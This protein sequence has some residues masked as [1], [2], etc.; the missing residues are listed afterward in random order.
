MCLH[1]ALGD[2]QAGGDGPVGEPLG[3]QCQHLALAFGELV[4]GSARRLR[5][6]SRA[7]IVG[8]TTVSRSARRAEGVDEVRDVEDAF[9]E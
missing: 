4:E 7:T 5:A 8:S 2:Q 6:K 3:D 9:F 1:G